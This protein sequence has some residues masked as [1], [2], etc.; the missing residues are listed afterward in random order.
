MLIQAHNKKG[1]QVSIRTSSI[2]ANQNL[3]KTIPLV[4]TLTKP[5]ASRGHTA[6][7]ICLAPTDFAIRSVA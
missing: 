3:Q 1:A 4:P 2:K 7:R 5:N 6:A